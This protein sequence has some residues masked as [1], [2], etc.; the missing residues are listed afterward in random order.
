MFKFKVV[1]NI[2]EFIQKCI[3]TSVKKTLNARVF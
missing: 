2:S 1:S 3:D